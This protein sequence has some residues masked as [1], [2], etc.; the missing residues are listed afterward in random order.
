MMLMRR[1]ESGLSVEALKEMADMYRSL[2]NS[3]ATSHMR[4]RLAKKAADYEADAGKLGK[5]RDR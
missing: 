5:A 2:A 1:K 3:A 4:D